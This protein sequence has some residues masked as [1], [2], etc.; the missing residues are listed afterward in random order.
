MPSP[1]RAIMTP[2]QWKRHLAETAPLLLA[3][4]REARAMLAHVGFHEDCD[5]PFKRS[6]KRALK[7]IDAAIAKATEG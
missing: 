4:L 6:W 2:A 7:E 1:T 5:A 3:Q